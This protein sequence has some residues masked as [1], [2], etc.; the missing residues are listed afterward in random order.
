ME[1]GK[2]TKEL[3]AQQEEEILLPIDGSNP[4][5][6]CPP[7]SPVNEALTKPK[8]GGMSRQTRD[9]HLSSLCRKQAG[10]T[11][12]LPPLTRRTAGKRHP[13]LGV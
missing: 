10:K 1:L 7:K 4:P 5:R 2:G 13:R 8:V 3:T 9:C 11:P 6:L 12:C